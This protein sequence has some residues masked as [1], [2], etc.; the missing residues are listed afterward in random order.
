MK[1]REVFFKKEKRTQIPHKK[2]KKKMA[3][4]A[5][6]YF[7]DVPNE[8]L[9]EIMAL[10]LRTCSDGS[11]Y[12]HIR[13]L[14]RVCVRWNKVFNKGYKEPS[15]CR[16]GETAFIKT[17]FR[18]ETRQIFWHSVLLCSITTAYHHTLNDLHINPEYISV[19]V[20]A[21]GVLEK[22]KDFLSEIHDKFILE[23]VPSDCLCA[24]GCKSPVCPEMQG[25]LRALETKWPELGQNFLCLDTWERSYLGPS[26]AFVLAWLLRAPDPILEALGILLNCSPEEETRK[27]I[28]FQRRYWD[29]EASWENFGRFLYPFPILE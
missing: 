3:G 14:P 19:I 15:G 2:T 17:P 28:L 27:M 22:Q 13:G 6:S 25:H 26:G 12:F 8:I 29:P 7:D 10:V 24:L 23:G 5:L 16:G 1:K 11:L 4:A 9:W 21:K 20:R 18:A